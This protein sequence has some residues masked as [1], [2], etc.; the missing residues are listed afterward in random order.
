MSSLPPVCE[1]YVFTPLCHSVHMGGVSSSVHAGIDT[2]GADTPPP[3]AQCMLGDKD[4]KRAVRI[5]LEC[6]LV[7]V[8]LSRKKNYKKYNRT[9]RK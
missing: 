3:P 5:L 2:P 4:N 6:I 8:I 7:L 1:D 9:T